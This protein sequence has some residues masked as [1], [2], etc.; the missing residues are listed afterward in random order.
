[1]E[2]SLLVPA[3]EESRPS[4][5]PEEEISLLSEG[6]GPLG[7]PGPTP[8]YAEIPRFVEPAE[9]TTTPVTSTVPC[10]CPSWKG[11]KSW[12]GIDINPNNSGQWVQ[13]YL[14]RDN[15]LPLPEW[16][17]EF[18][19]L[20]TLWMGVVMIPKLKYG[21]P[22]SCGLPPTSHPEGSAWHL[23]HPTLPGSAR[24]KR[25]FCASRLRVTQNYQEVQREEMVA[26]AIVLQMCAI[27]AGA[28]PNVFC[29]VVQEFHDCLVPMVE[30]GNSF[31]MEN[32][33]WEG[34]RKDPMATTPSKRFPALMPKVEEPT[35]A[36][37][38]NPPPASEQ[39]GAVS[40]EDLALLLRWWPPP[41]RFSPLGSNDP[42]TPP[43]E[44]VYGH[45]AMP[46]GTVLDLTALESLQ[47]TISHT[48]VMG[49]VHYHLQDHSI[50]MRSLSDT[51]SQEH[52]EPSPKIEEHWAIIMFPFILKTPFPSIDP[53]KY[54]PPK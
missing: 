41:P 32:E 52:L 26:L 34:V 36:T 25:I 15:R 20:S 29:R 19:L 54:S 11:K 21:L 43:L 22:G 27:C 5:T 8:R 17:E 31:N 16:W 10:S 3:E 6:D 35:G 38:P 14:E 49:E 53:S 39:E 24:K 28:S 13:A 4:P 51:F 42:A 7:V 46:M 30:E 18:C 45:G 40:P 2:A 37:A 50:S 1:M 9:W 47:V 12:E 44:D 48:P 23:D 33:I